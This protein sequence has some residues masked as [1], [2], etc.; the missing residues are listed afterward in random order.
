MTIHKHNN[1]QNNIILPQWDAPDNI[2]SLQTT[3]CGGC[4]KAPFES[5]N[6]G[7]HVDDNIHDVK[8][9]RQKLAERLPSEPVW[10]NQIHSNTVVDAGSTVTGIDADGS[11]TIR[12]NVVSVIMTADCLPV[13]ICNRQGNA[14]A[15]I[16]AGWRGLVNGILEQGVKKLLSAGRC[17]PE[18]LLVWLGPAIGPD[19]FEVGD[20]VRQAFLDKAPDKSPGKTETAKCFIPSKL[21]LFENK[22]SPLKISLSSKTPSLKRK[23]LADIYQLARIRL[24]HV[25]VENFS[26]GTYC[27]Y[28]ESDQFYSYRRDG[29]TGRMAS[30]IWIE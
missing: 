12:S 24:L 27:T 30:L 2:K 18:D 7:E 28:K 10:L 25:G 4:S 3:R 16:H 17:Q 14:V 5:F 26:G 8:K 13:L 29:K 1:Y 22:T 21:H 11:Y 15:A 6:L 19:M 9:N 20:E 23:W